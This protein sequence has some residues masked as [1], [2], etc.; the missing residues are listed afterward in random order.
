MKTP[1]FLSATTI[2]AAAASLAS[3]ENLT[4]D[5]A[6]DAQGFAGV[7]WQAG[8]PAGWPG[9][10]GTVMQ[11]HTAG[12]WQMVMT[13]EFAWG[14]GG[15]SA[16]QQTAM[17]ALANLGNA[18]FSF[19]LMVNGTSFPAGVS[20]WFQAAVVGNSDGS[21]TW[22]QIGDIFTASGWHPADDPTLISMHFDYA[23][24]QLGWQPGDNWFQFWTG[25]NSDNA[26]P[27]NFYIDNV[28]AYAVPEPSALAVLGLGL[29]AVLGLRRRG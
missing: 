5:F 24:T 3:A 28:M 18:R 26:A 21:A 16:N 14:P 29:A 22:T 15:G 8:A 7:T 1:L 13:K 17:Q 27:V 11:A 4:Y 20:T 12:G 6:T 23:F 9:L 25:A 10:P 2:L 19:D